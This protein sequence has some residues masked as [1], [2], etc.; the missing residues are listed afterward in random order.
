[1]KKIFSDPQEMHSSL[2]YFD[3]EI[4]SGDSTNFP[5]RL[6]FLQFIT[7]F[8]E[9]NNKIFIF[10]VSSLYL[11]LIITSFRTFKRVSNSPLKRSRQRIK[12]KSFLK[13]KSLGLETNHTIIILRLLS[14][15]EHFLAVQL[16]ILCFSAY[17]LCDFSLAWSPGKNNFWS[18]NANRTLQVF[19]IV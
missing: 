19:I 10:K 7:T 18:R 17:C 11:L 3:S 2:F 12:K 14:L 4:K 9:R 6:M 15:R 1:M 16:F 5:L 8:N 13:C